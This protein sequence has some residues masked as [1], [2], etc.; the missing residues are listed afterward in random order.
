MNA[1]GI[2][3][4]LISLTAV[5]SYINYRYLKLPKSIGLTLITVALSLFLAGLGR[6]GLN[7]DAFATKLLD[8]IGFTDTF[9]HGM[10]GFLLFAG[11][12]HINARELAKHKVIVGLL[13]T[14]TVVLSTFLIGFSTYGLI[15]FL[16]I[17]IPL[18]Y[19]LVFGAL[20]SP[21][22]PIATLSILKSAKAPKAL[23]MKIA[24]ES[25][26][27]DGMGIVLFVILM[28]M[29]SGTETWSFSE[30]TLFFLRQFAGGLALGIIMGCLAARFL[31]SID[32]YEVAVIL[33]L[34][35][36]TGGYSFAHSIANV[37]GAICMAVA[38]L[39]VGS[40]LQNGN[41]SKNTLQRLDNFWELLDGV[42]NALLFV[43]I[44]LEL[45]TIHFNVLTTIAAIAAIVIT[46]IARWISVV[47][48]V[49]WLAMFR[50]YNPNVV[51]I[52]TWGGLRGG[53]SIALALTVPEPARD[54]IL[55]ITYAVVVFSIMVQGLSL[56]TLI[57]K[58]TCRNNTPV[59]G[60]IPFQFFPISLGT[61]A[62][63]TV[64]SSTSFMGLPA[65]AFIGLPATF[66]GRAHDDMLGRT[67]E[68]NENCVEHDNHVRDSTTVEV[69]VSDDTEDDDAEPGFNGI[70]VYAPYS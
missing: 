65:G 15:F 9:L 54:F 56:N 16:G 69:N 45:L 60:K 25:L 14:V 51:L 68:G 62:I 46:L 31:R 35:V 17:D 43:F 70:G 47:V 50:K 7:V 20:I 10:L 64:P 39:V 36:V 49:A 19:C 33:T 58:I 29:A 55:T 18:E 23:E 21:T 61:P 42:L 32:N 48:P 4:I 2:I 28:A 66:M 5:C 34:A 13:A 41:M 53:I 59:L 24:G 8:G 63:N 27:N 30:S 26:F 22:D 11:S 3:G 52:M 40:S 6:L 1:E 67:T 37:S 12:L 57:R 44:G 38:G